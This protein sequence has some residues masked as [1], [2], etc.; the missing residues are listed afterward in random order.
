MNKNE[1]GGNRGAKQA[2]RFDP[3]L[4]VKGGNVLEINKYESTR[5]QG[6]TWKTVTSNES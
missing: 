1:G 6:S 2:F 4:H 5:E 3:L